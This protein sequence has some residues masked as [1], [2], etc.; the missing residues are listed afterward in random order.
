M[1]ESS[2]LFRDLLSSS[3]SFSSSSEICASLAVCKLLRM[4]IVSDLAEAHVGMPSSFR[5][6]VE[7]RYNPIAWVFLF[8]VICVLL[9]LLLLLCRLP[10]LFLL[11]LIFYVCC[12][13]FMTILPFFQFSP[14][15]ASS[16]TALCPFQ[17][18]IG[19]WSH[20]LAFKRIQQ[21]KQS[22]VCVV[23]CCGVLWCAVFTFPAWSSTLG[24]I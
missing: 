6:A 20:S 13:C 5:S 14:L 17:V 10:A 7:I 22:C 15:V 21:Q 2:V 11:F 9:L 3:E 18:C 12:C 16:C 24:S 19:L 4:R 1:P 8:C 23:L